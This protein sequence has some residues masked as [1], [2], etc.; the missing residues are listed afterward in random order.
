[1]LCA[2]YSML[3]TCMHE[4]ADIELIISHLCCLSH[5]SLSYLRFLLRYTNLHLTSSLTLTLDVVLV[6]YFYV[7]L[8]Y[9][10]NN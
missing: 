5:A 3:Y 2:V 10:N 8:V 7:Y 9:D 6:L 4:T 1:M